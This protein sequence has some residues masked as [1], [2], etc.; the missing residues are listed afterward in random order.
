MTTDIV[1]KYSTDISSQQTTLGT[2]EDALKTNPSDEVA[3]LNYQR[4]MNV[5]TSFIEMISASLNKQ[6]EMVQFMV[7]KL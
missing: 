5:H 7:Q 3:M 2:D 4:D 1:T 6:S